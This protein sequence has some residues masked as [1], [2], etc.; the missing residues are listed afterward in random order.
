MDIRMRK[1]NK[2]I[3]K[4]CTSI[5]CVYTLC[6]SQDSSLH[7]TSLAQLMVQRVRSIQ[8]AQDFIFSF[9]SFFLLKILNYST[10]QADKNALHELNYTLL[11]RNHTSICYV[12]RNKYDDRQKKHWSEKA[13]KY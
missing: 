8:N 4:L 10:A 6:V 1:T 7:E 2:Y 12:F 13:K 11:Q 3:F 5:L 9:N